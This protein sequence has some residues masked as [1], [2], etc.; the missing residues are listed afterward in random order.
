MSVDH[1][2]EQLEAAFE[3]ATNPGFKAR[4]ISEYRQI[5]GWVGHRVDLDRAKILDFGCGQG[6]AAASFAC[7]HPE[8]SVVGLDIAPVAEPALNAMYQAQIGRDLPRNIRFATASPGHIPDSG[9]YDLIYAW[10]VFVHVREDIILDLLKTLRSRL[11]KNGVLFIQANPLYFSPR[12]SHLYNYFKSPW[13]HLIL[14]LDTL[15]E[16]VLSDHATDSAKR[17]WAQF[18]EL[19]RLTAKDILGRA[20]EAGFKLVRE[21]SFSTDIVPPPRLTR[22]YD[23]DVLM[24]TELLALFE[25]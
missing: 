17:E 4:A 14:S 5:R 3:R 12:G 2:T 20:L 10:S 13:H 9:G 11:N 1:T 19:N 22:V 16:G 15:Q 24:T 6:I 8:A 23:K 7:R 21:Q 18:L 25:R